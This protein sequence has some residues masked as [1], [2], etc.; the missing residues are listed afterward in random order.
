MSKPRTAPASVLALLLV[1]SAGA[2]EFDPDALADQT[3]GTNWLAHGRTHYEQRYSPLDEINA[4]TIG[5]LGL[6]WSIDLPEE[7][8]HLV[9][10]TLVVDGVLYVTGDFSAVTAIDA[11]TRKVLWRYDPKVTEH[12]GETLRTLWG[13]SRGVAYWNGKIYVGAGDGRLIA[14]DSKSGEEVWSTM[15]VEPGSFYYVTGAPRAFN[16]K[17]VIGN[18]GTEMGPARGYVTAYDAETGEQAWRFYVV[19][20]NPADGFEDNAQR[21]AAA[22]WTGE[23]WKHGGGGNVWN[24]ITYD[25][26]FNHVYLGTGNGSPWNQKIRSPGGGDNLFLCSIVAL[27]ADTGKYKWHYQ[28]VPGETW[29]FNS[30]MDIV[31]MDFKVRDRTVKAL[32]HAPKNGF[33]YIL[34]RQNGR[35]LSA[36]PYAKVTWATEV[37][38][39]TGKPVEVAGSRYEDGEILMYPGPL[40]AH[41]WQPMSWNPNTHLMYFTVHDVAGYYND[42]KIRKATFQAEGHQFDVGVAYGADDIAADASVN[43]LMAWNPLTQSPAWHVPNPPGWH[44]GTMTTAGNLVF[45]GLGTG[46]FIAYRADDGEKL[47]EFDAKH[48]IAAP[49]VTFTVDGRQHIA[50][51]VGWGGGL[52]MLGGT[53]GAQHG[54]PYKAHPR[55]LLVFAL[56]GSASL[57]ET[58]PPMFVTPIDDPSFETDPA[59]VAAGEAHWSKNCAWCHGPAAVAS[60]GTPDLRASG[61]MLSLDAM[62][63]VIQNG[64]RIRQGMPKFTAFDRDDLEALQHYVRARG[65]CRIVGTTGRRRVGMT[66]VRAFSAC[67][68]RPS[69]TRR[70]PETTRRP[71]TAGSASSTCRRSRSRDRS[72]RTCSRA[73]P[74]TAAP[75]AAPSAR[76]RR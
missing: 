60:G 47:W 70:N 57:P 66:F 13:T 48:G 18:G 6:A 31:S 37:D 26:D 51:P 11:R 65:A 29:D 41:N 40:G 38:M 56:E 2:A 25:P 35:L 36:K 14:V 53:M 16:G 74:T 32:M 63:D 17:V 24:A 45:Q 46:Q 42:T 8:R 43:G 61:V 20:G 5:R 22:T 9:S 10:T 62:A 52:A 50:L 28:T 75:P 72:S 64:A 33:F 44:A 3:D 39:K 67:D 71:E 21:M 54:W 76:A 15:T 59:K 12:A 69:R 68:R 30:A 23:W 7:H 27:D 73:R 55:R 58:P 49:P 19:P 1:A 4:D 34:N